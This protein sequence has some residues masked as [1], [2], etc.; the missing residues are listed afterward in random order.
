MRSLIQSAALAL[1]ALLPFTAQ[2][3]VMTLPADG[4][5]V[6]SV[7]SS[8]AWVTENTFT[9]DNV[10]FWTFEI[11]Q[12]TTLSVDILADISFGISVYMGKIADEFATMFFSNSGDFTD[13][14]LTYVGGTPAI[15]GVGG[16]LSGLFLDTP[17]MF[18]LAVGGA[19]GFDLPGGPFG[20][21]LNVVT[22]TVPEPSSLALMLASGL[23]LFARRRS[24]KNA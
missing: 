5:Y 1:L 13:G 9:E 22:A 11:T 19:E 10:D 4:Q 3:G 6:D 7:Q 23:A 15:P 24:A 20:Y 14:S 18:T 2:A 8:N 17:G 12:P 21:T 16:S